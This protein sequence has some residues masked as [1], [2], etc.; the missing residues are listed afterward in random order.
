MSFT[1]KL[2]K[3]IKVGNIKLR[4]RVVMLWDGAGYLVGCPT[5]SSGLS[6]VSS[7]QPENDK[8]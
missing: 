6:K 1:K 4:N 5:C 2:F 3:P 8:A 7:I